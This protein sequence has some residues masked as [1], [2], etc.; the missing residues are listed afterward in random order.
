MIVSDRANAK[1][2]PLVIHNIG[3]GTMEEDR[4]FEFKFTGHYRIGKFT[5]ARTNAGHR[6]DR[7]QSANSAIVS[8]PPGVRSEREKQNQTAKR[9]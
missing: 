9:R 4:L 2:Q 7:T 6:G 1:G 5:P 3:S 8:R